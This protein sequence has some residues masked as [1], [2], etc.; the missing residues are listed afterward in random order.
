MQA[1]LSSYLAMQ[2][3]CEVAGGTGK[4]AELLE[5]SPQAVSQVKNGS[6]RV[7]DVWCPQIERMT[8]E[9]GRPVRCEELRPDVDWGYL[10]T[11]TA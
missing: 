9:R 1:K 3:A 2:V 8:R 5:V 4:L 7:P 11:V 10:R 6:R